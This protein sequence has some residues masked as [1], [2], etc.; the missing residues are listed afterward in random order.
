MAE[1]GL[2]PDDL[3]IVVD[4]V[5]LATGRIRIRRQGSHGGHNGLVSICESIATESFARLRVGVGPAPSGVDL[6]E[7]V[8]E[9]MAGEAW[10]LLLDGVDRAAEAVRFLCREGMAAAMTRYNPAPPL[11]ENGS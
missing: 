3:L 9:P 2:L 6:A 7:F 1:E 5:V 10:Q 11:P 4:D 8:L